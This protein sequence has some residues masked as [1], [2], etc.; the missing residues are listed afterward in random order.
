MSSDGEGDAQEHALQVRHQR[1][2][3]ARDHERAERDE[4][5]SADDV[6]QA[7]V[8]AHHSDGSGR[9]AESEGEE[10]ERDAETER[11]CEAEE[12]AACSGCLI[13]GHPED[14][15]EGGADAGCP[16]YAESDAQQGGSRQ[17]DPSAHA[18][19]HGALRE[20]EAADED[21]AH[22]DDER[23]ATNKQF[24]TKSF[25]AKEDPAKLVENSSS[26]EPY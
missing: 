7:D 14:D 13:E 3:Q 11:V 15:G 2:P 19:P 17:S 16:T 26:E 18:W 9:P 4:E 23:A 6:D 24:W 20:P 8:A 21:H 5:C 10:D 1:G 25:F 12:R 22:D